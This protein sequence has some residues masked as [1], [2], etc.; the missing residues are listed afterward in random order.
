MKRRASGLGTLYQPSYRLHG[1]LCHSATWWCSY[2]VDGRR[3]MEST[4]QTKKKPA[5]D[6][7]RERIAARD[8]GSPAKR[9]SGGLTF[10]DLAAMI[11][12]D[13]KAN[14]RR[15]AASRLEPSLIHLRAFF[16]GP[17]QAITIDRVTAYVAHRRAVARPATVNREL[18]TLRRALNLAYRAGKLARVPHIKALAEN[19]ARK[20]FFEAEQFQAVLANAPEYLR[21]LLEAYYV[22]GW[23]R[24]E[25]LSRE[26]RH[27]D[28]KAGWLRLEPGETKNGRGRMFPLVPR[29]RAVLEA[30][31]RGTVD[32]ER[33]LGKRIPWLFHRAGGQI[34]SF[35]GAWEL[36]RVAA[37][38]P[39]RLIHDFRRTAVRNL[40]RAGVAQRTAM[41][42]V[43]LETDSMFRRYGIVDETMLRE[44]GEKLAK[45][46]T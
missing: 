31:E 32:L 1:K 35:R 18:A 5:E 27:L 26:R 8:A 19:N 14:D 45:L 20:G 34:K 44:A 39:G 12:A 7:L 24:E 23:R 10:A 33:L 21:P 25:L 40:I 29:L 11:R 17:A 3:V 43:G 6:F 9:A 13:Y 42:L 4:G 2:T 30:Q 41:E 36:A 16:E 46:P 15:S 22:T 37:G 38:V 28:L